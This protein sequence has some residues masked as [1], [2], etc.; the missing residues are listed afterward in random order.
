ML[1]PFIVVPK[2]HKERFLF[3]VFFSLSPSTS[4][5]GY[6]SIIGRWRK[7]IPLFPFRVVMI[8]E[9]IR[10]AANETETAIAFSFRRCRRALFRRL[11]TFA[12][13]EYTSRS[14]RRFV[15]RQ[16]SFGK[17]RFVFKIIERSL[18][19]LFV[20]FKKSKIKHYIF[21]HHS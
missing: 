15:R 13:R 10:T 12:V 9:M 20:F 16:P 1:R 8:F 4:T 5:M 19:S 17:H 7:K 3:F 2:K 14:R 18:G 11:Y 6:R 21:K